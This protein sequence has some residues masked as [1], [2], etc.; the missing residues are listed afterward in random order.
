MGALGVHTFVS[1][2]IL[3]IFSVVMNPASYSRLRLPVAAY[4][5]CGLILLLCS[6]VSSFAE[7]TGLY[8]LSMSMIGI[9]IYKVLQNVRT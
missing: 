3:M 2:A 4:Q 8:F 6:I 7:C 9:Q 5:D 1:W